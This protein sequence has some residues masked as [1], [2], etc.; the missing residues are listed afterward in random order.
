MTPKEY[1][2]R[3]LV[4]LVTDNKKDTFSMCGLG[5]SGE[6]GEINDILKKWLY[7]KRGKSLDTE[8]LKDEIGDVLWYLSIL[9]FEI[10]F[11]LEEIMEHNIAKLEKRHGN[12]FRPRYES[13]S[14]SSE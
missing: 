5:L 6:V 3:A 9:A 10:G 13:D 7:H 2:E 4:T 1:Q 11:T 12:G 14:G 8:K